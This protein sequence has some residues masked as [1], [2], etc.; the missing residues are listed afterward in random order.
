MQLTEL[1]SDRLGESETEEEFFGGGLV[2]GNIGNIAEH[3]FLS[4]FP[5]LLSFSYNRLN[6]IPTYLLPPIIPNKGN[7]STKHNNKTETF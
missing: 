4:Y 7:D 5:S 3:E 6:A 2:A 1:F